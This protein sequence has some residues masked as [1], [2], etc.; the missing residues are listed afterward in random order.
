[1]EDT[2]PSP[3]AAIVKVGYVPV[4]LIPV[5][6]FK[7]TVWSGAVLV[8]VIE[9]DVVMGPPLTLMP[10]PAVRSTDVTVPKVTVHSPKRHL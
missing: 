2:V 1:V 7:T 4:T 3:V 10:V 6:E 8:T 5:P 9:P